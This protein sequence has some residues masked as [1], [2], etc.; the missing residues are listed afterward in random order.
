MPLLKPKKYERKPKFI[1]RFIKSK[2]MELE[3]KNRKQRL[4]IAYDIWR[5]K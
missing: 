4:A 2:R 3:F 5:K 1:Q